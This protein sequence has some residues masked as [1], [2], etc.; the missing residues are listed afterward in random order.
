MPNHVTNVLQI[1]GTP[2]QVKEVRDSIRGVDAIDFDKLIPMPPELDIGC[3]GYAMF[4]EGLKRKGIQGIPD[5]AKIFGRSLTDEDRKNLEPYLANL[6]T[7]GYVT[8]YDWC[9]NKWGTKWSAYSIKVLE[10]HIIKFDTA[11]NTPTPIYEAL[12]ARFPDIEFVVEYADEDIG[13]NLGRLTYKK[14]L[15]NHLSPGEDYSK[16]AR[17]FAYQIK[18]YS[19][20]LIEECESGYPGGL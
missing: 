10:N 20:E 8:W 2:E 13:R 5:D 17:M 19:Q 1:N 6:K 15:K 9:R 14:V 12:A 4:V 16:E 7:F 18:G 11:W 3:D